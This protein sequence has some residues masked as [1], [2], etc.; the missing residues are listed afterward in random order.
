VNDN[1]ATVKHI[2]DMRNAQEHPKVDCKLTIGDF[3]IEAGNVVRPPIWE[4]SQHNPQRVDLGMV[5]I[6]NFLLE[7][8]EL[9]VIF[10]VLSS[11][12][13]AF[14]YQVARIPEAEI[15][16]ECPICY[17]PHLDIEAWLRSKAPQVPE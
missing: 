3:T 9:L 10:C 2:L 4:L 13:L 17:V 8:A 6:T 14:P 5:E 12:K 1:D 15:K 16:K 11:D 7:F